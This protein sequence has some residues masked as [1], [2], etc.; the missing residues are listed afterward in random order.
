M[1]LII[2]SIFTFFLISNC[3]LNKVI[4]QHGVKFLEKKQAK[5]SINSSNSNDIIKLLGPPSTKSTFDKDMWIYIERVTSSSKIT[6][7][8]KKSLI[9]NN[10][11]ILEIN[12]K[13]VLTEKIF[14][15]KEKMNNLD[16]SE[17]FTQ[18]SSRQKSVIYDFLSTLRKK[19]NDPL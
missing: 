3:T 9:E 8:G 1:R 2:Y 14:L 4:S 6:K 15:D 19:I 16:F 7:L 18:M 5:L 12:N 10:I 17:D 13:G 11:L